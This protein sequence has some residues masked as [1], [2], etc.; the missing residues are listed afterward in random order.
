MQNTLYI[1]NSALTWTYRPAKKE[2]SLQ[3]VLEEDKNDPKQL[4]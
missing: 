4:Q 1:A 3:Y 2:Q